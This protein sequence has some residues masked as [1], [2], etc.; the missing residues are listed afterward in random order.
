[1]PLVNP[2][3]IALIPGQSYRL[4]FNSGGGKPDQANATY[5]PVNG[6]N[7]F[8]YSNGSTVNTNTERVTIN[9]LQGGRRKNTRSKSSKNKRKTRRN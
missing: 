8:T 7:R 1:M 9:S 2:G 3:K 5:S 6:R 4:S